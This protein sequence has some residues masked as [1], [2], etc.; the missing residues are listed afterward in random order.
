M[1]AQQRGPT[2]AG[3]SPVR[4]N[5][6]A[7]DP[8]V[9]VGAGSAR[10]SFWLLV[11]ALA[12]IT[13][14]AYQSVWQ[15]GF[16]WDDDL[17]VTQNL[18]L[19]TLHGLYRIW[20][21]PLKDQQY[22]PLQLTSFWI[23][24]HLWGT[25]PFG[26]HAVNILLH[27]LNAV[28]LWMVLRRLGVPGAWLAA[29]IFA[30]HPVQ[31]ES[32]AW[33]TEIKNLLSTTFYFGAMLAFFRFRPLP[34]AATGTVA[35]RGKAGGRLGEPSLPTTTAATPKVFGAQSDRQRRQSGDSE[36]DL[37]AGESPHSK[38][39]AEAQPSETARLGTADA[40]PGRAEARPSETARLGTPYTTREQ[41]ADATPSRAEARPS[42]PEEIGAG[43]GRRATTSGQWRYYWL[44][45]GLFLCAL[46]SKTV[47]CSLPAIL[48]LL[49][50][51]KRG[52]VKR[53]DIAQLSPMFLLGM[54]LGLTTAWLERHHVYAS[55]P[56]WS[57]TLLQRCLLAGR[58]M[59][60]YAGKLLWPRPLI[61]IYPHWEIDPGAWW[62]Y[63]FPAAAL[64]MLLTLWSLRWRIGKGPLVAMLSFG[65]TLFPALGFFNVYPFRFSYVADHFQYLASAALIPLVT[66]AGAA[67]CQRAGELGREL[68]VAVAA[69]VL[70]ALGAT[71]WGQGHV[72]RDAETLWRDTLA[73]NPRCWMAHGNLG[74]ILV[75]SG[76]MAEGIGQYEQA[77]RLKP[78]YT[79][80][81]INLGS[82]LLYEGQVSQAIE[83][84]Q[85][86]LK[87]KPDSADAHTQ[88]GI[89]LDRTGRPSEA[90]AHYEQA[91]R[92][93]PNYVQALNNLAWYLATRPPVDGGDGA[94]AVKLAE[95]ASQLTGNR[96]PASLDVLAAAC[97]AAGRFDDAIATAQRA[98]ELA[99]SA[100][101][102][103]L[104]RGIEARLDLYRHG[105]P[106]YSSQ[107]D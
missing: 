95:R 97:A 12:A 64:A 13:F 26:Y 44:A 89:A 94:R 92:L 42:E 73:K 18:S 88:M 87:L 45:N 5:N 86:A 99:R 69:I 82:A 31:V 102:P 76:R 37:R 3:A 93:K 51:W 104:A 20:F 67:V 9:G 54:T 48:L 40:T 84:L 63:L 23:E 83:Q 8:D 78:D 70:V 27:A 7:E 50:W 101:Q 74:A 21:E 72:Y 29:A 75:S 25:R 58:V 15:A 10:Y 11:L 36:H 68:G 4:R 96:A 60:F 2:A 17:H 106:Y 53:Q 43:W 80:A 35:V 85:H 103:M 57:L 65:G 22:Y 105:R 100:S 41:A 38:G 34:T 1:A 90:A 28:L 56:E 62:Q 30:V 19:R 52:T 79:E 39:R 66:S 91:L 81:R 59:W 61:F 77:L 107:S 46:L 33:V 55:G 49:I 47:A 71:T 98:L 6:C 24:Y 16:I 32:V 14:A